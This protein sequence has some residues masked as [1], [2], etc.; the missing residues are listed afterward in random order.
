MGLSEAEK[1]AH[2]YKPNYPPVSLVSIFYG[3]RIVAGCRIDNVG[4]CE[5]ST[6]LALGH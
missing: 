2:L 6:C 3:S 5:L 4:L 1:F